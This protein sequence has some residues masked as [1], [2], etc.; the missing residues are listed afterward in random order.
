MHA[1]DK[2]YWENH[3]ASPTG[4]GAKQEPPVNPYL[5]AETTDLPASTALDAGCGTGTEA[6]WLAE[7]G[8]QVTAADLSAN[9]LAA[10]RSRADAAGLSDRVAWVETDLMRWQPNDTWDLVVTSYAHPDLGQ[11]ALYQHVASWIAAGGTLLII[12]HLHGP[13]AD[14]GHPDD[15]SATGAEIAT[16]LPSPEWHIETSYENVRTVQASGRTV[17]LRDVVV[18][19]TRHPFTSKE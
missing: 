15:A 4:A 18:R 8:W 3:W 1:F 10:A 9:A 19:A 7:H 17:Q 12:G 2:T 14:H 6:L 11:L 16:L 13:H 5:P